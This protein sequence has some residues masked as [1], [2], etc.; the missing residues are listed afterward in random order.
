MNEYFTLLWSLIS[1]GLIVLS[2]L[3]LLDFVIGVIVALVARNFKWE[4]LMHYL[5]SDVMP[6]LGWVVVVILSTIPAGLTPPGGVLPVA[7][8]VVYGTVFLGIL[9]SILG[10]LADM[11]VLQKPLNRIGIGSMPI[12]DKPQ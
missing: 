2:G 12:A 1:G 5:T 11:G 9:G 7:T 8:G 10:S 6:I 4:Y 3:T